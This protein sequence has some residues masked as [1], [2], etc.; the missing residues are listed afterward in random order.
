M[1]TSDA[2]AAL[3]AVAIRAQTY[4]GGRQFDTLCRRTADHPCK[5]RNTIKRYVLDQ[6]SRVTAQSDKLDRKNAAVEVGFYRKP[7][8]K[9]ASFIMLREEHF[10]LAQLPEALLQCAIGWILGFT[11]V[12]ANRNLADLE[13]ELQG[14]I[15]CRQPRMI[16]AIDRLKHAMAA[17]LERPASVRP[18]VVAGLSIIAL[19]GSMAPIDKHSG[20]RF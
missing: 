20:N 2:G 15:D 16:A 10:E 9:I 17:K 14:P 11:L 12:N 19:E 1:A 8:G 7:I 4:A 13:N 6:H 3:C 5:G 18:S